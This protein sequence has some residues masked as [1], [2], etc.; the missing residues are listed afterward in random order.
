MIQRI[1]AVKFRMDDGGGNQDIDGYS[2]VHEC[3]S[4]KI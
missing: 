3:D 1:T 2:K 4:S